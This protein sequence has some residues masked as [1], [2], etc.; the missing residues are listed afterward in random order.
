ME[1]SKR[2]PFPSVLMANRRVVV[3]AF[4]ILLIVVSYVLA[5]LLRFDFYVPSETWNR[6]FVTLPLLLVFRLSAFAFFKLHKGMWRYVGM[7][8]LL[9]IL[10]AE[11]LSS[12]LFG[13]TVLTF[14]RLGFPRSVLFLDWLVCFVFVGG[15]RLT[16]RAFRENA[17]PDARTGARRGVIV[18]AGDAGEILAREI[19][20]NRALDYQVVGFVDDD[21][22]KRGRTIHG[23]GV[24]GSTGDLVSLCRSYKIDE[25]LI[26]VPSADRYERRHI[27]K[28][29]QSAG[30]PFK[31]VPDL[32]ALLQGK[33]TIDQLQEVTPEDVLG[34]DA[35]QLDTDRV[36]HEIQGKAIMITGG[37]GSIG[38]EL[39]RQ[40]ATFQPGVLVLFDRAE[41][42][43][44]FA[45]LEL[46][47]LHPALKIVPIVG[48]ILDAA[49]VDDVMN[50]WRPDVVYHAAAYKHVPLMEGQPF[51][52]IKNNVF[53][54]EIVATAARK[55]GVKKFVLI[56]TD[57]AVRPVGV[58]GTTKRISECILLSFGGCDTSF[59]A[60]RFGNVLGSDGSVLPLFKW[61]IASQGA[62]KVTHEDATRYFMLLSEAAQLVLQA[63]TM[64]K[65]GEVFFLDMGEPVKILDLATN[66]VRLSG[67]RP[68]KD[69][70]I[71]VTGLRPGERL[72]E[73][74]V[75]DNE[76]M[77]ATEH[78]KVLMVQN[79]D[80]DGNAFLRDLDALRE[81]VAAR[82][83]HATTTHL[84]TM[85]AAAG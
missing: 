46:R 84:K 59:V 51:E 53:G 22:K 2:A 11:T 25:I 39:C 76:T 21:R 72:T 43:L 34:R 20:R 77:V 69:I 56:S 78:E 55:R 29:C 23:I 37:A 6:F 50:Q 68:G 71:Q 8:D 74:L 63:G 85:A 12:V 9:A 81:L 32:G 40:V 1:S 47:R 38:S 60:V 58:M 3:I 44:Y 10:K 52:A 54:T 7:P 83:H 66:L 33:A 80:F 31:T 41:S 17:S 15:A 70:D 79:H 49:H 24:L 28:Q 62:L 57:K 27:L 16:L 19:A 30:I 13:I 67:M 36:R 48:D 73:A 4:H 18:G 5:F 61:Q 35:I 65:G 45:H 26:A 82:D 14:F 75:L 64:G 42:N